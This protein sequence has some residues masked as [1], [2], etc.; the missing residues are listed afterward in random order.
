M[1]ELLI[2]SRAIH[3]GSCMVLLSVFMVRLLIER[4]AAKDRPGPRWLAGA[5]LAFAA[6]SGFLWLWASVAGMSGSSLKDALNLQLFTLVLGQTP[7]GKV[8]VVRSG[9][10]VLLGVTLCLPRRTWVWIAGASL[11][12]ALTGSISWLGHAGASEGGRRPLMLAADV[13]HL[14]A[15]SLWPA[16]LL[17]FGLLLRRQMQQSAPGAPGAPGALGA[18]YVAARRFSGMSLAAVAVIAA[19]GCVNAYFLVGSFHALAA[20]GYGRLL[21]AKLSL[22]G[23]AAILGAWNLLVHEPRL[24]ADPGA[25]AA[26]RRK[27]WAEVA[28]GMGIVAVV[29]IMGTLPP[30]SSPGG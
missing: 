24:L 7:P 12:A 25:L 23:I 26:M 3:F 30:G 2:L 13:S 29:A 4:P 16:G 18:A 22:F 20:T 10:A 27:V 11:A 28:L 14:L 15:V 8:W 17:P 19:S 1:Y 21:I 9:I 6:G 5:C